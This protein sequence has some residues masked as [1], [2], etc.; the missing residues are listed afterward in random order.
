MKTIL[1]ALS[2]LL[3][4]CGS[5]F[6]APAIDFT[7]LGPTAA[8]MSAFNAAQNDTTSFAGVS[9]AGFTYGGGTTF[10]TGSGYL[11]LRNDP[12]DL[13]LGYCSEGSNCGTTSTLGNGDWNELSN[14]YKDEIIR[15]TLP[16]GKVWTDIFVSSLDEGGSG[17]NETGTLYWSDV[18]NPNLNTLTTKAIF[19]HNQID[20]PGGAEVVEGSIWSQLSGIDVSTLERRSGS[21]ASATPPMARLMQRAISTLVKRMPPSE[22]AALVG[23]NGKMAASARRAMS[24]PR[25]MRVIVAGL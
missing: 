11:W 14:N 16:T 24:A 13:G 9:I 1:R 22:K 15:L 23:W 17:N 21:A 18:A 4:S 19:S 20:P 25:V 5:A 2:V 10:S 12:E 8:Q 6:A 3:A 7:G